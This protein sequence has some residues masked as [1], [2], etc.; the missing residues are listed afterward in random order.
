MTRAIFAVAVLGAICS[1]VGCGDGGG[2]S[3]STGDGATAAGDKA[4]SGSGK[5]AD[6]AAPE[7]TYFRD[8]ATLVGLEFRHE[9]GAD[10]RRL[11]PESMGAGAALADFDGDGLL[12]CYLIDGCGFEGGKS[13]ATGRN[14]MF[15]QTAEGRFEDV[16][17]SSGTGHTGYGMGCAVADYDG[18]G[19]RDLYLTNLGPDVLYRNDGNGRFTDV[20]SEAGIDCPDWGASATFFDYDRDGD[21]DLFVV[22]YIDWTVA[23][24]VECF[25]GGKLVYCTP[26][27]YQGMPNKLFR[28][29]GKGRFVDVSKEV[30][31]TEH[32]GKGLGV[33]VADF[34]GDGW[35]DVYVANDGVRNFLFQNLEG[36][37]FEEVGVESGSAYNEFGN[38]EAGMGVDFADLDG[39][40]KP[41]VVVTNLDNELN[42][43]FI[44]AGDESFEEKSRPLGLGAPSN[45]FVG[46][47]CL[48]H[49]FDRDGDRDLYVTNGHII[50]NIKEINSSLSHAQ[51]DF[52]FLQD[53]TGRF[54][55]VLIA[56]KEVPARVG[57]SI[58]AGDY[59][60]DGDLD[61]L[62]TSCGG[63][64]L[65]L[66]N[67]A[68]KG[69]HWVGIELKA[70][71][72]NTG[73]VGAI[74]RV[75]LKGR[76]HQEVMLPRGNYLGAHD[77]RRIIGL[78]DAESVQKITV[79]WP[80][81]STKVVE[82]PAIDR[83]HTIEK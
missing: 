18:D 26:D 37:S 2:S 80:D 48:M 31:L 11:M 55:E 58:A 42:N 41:D 52:L 33:G 82:S 35:P 63:S 78:G 43:A 62:V 68:G 76:T 56:S 21:L 74:V 47:A 15:R 44:N 12:D 25:S 24:N 79:T 1:M 77:H 14:R 54:E 64:P 19:D 17:E 81:G 72:P 8:V 57:R 4:G 69:H 3:P 75:D 22:Q 32:L 39:D 40:E 36:K 9:T 45:P 50:D 61:L 10:G 28:N 38:A 83:Y 20:T 70:P 30:G 73:A 51:N 13:P 29:E 46:F 60:N 7:A 71:A 53:S 49:D 59:D 23:K 6:A 16:T 65:L 5:R 67:D 66:R 27:A 34:D